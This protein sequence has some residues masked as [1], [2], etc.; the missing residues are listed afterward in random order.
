MQYGLIFCLYVS[1][2]WI[3]LLRCQAL[4]TVISKL[5]LKYETWF[6]SHSMTAQAVSGGFFGIGNRG[7]HAVVEASALGSHQ[8]ARNRHQ[9][10]GS[11]C[12]VGH[13]CPLLCDVKCPWPSLGLQEIPAAFGHC[14]QELWGLIPFLFYLRWL[15]FVVNSL[16]W[17]RGWLFWSALTSNTGP[18]FPASHGRVLSWLDWWTRGETL[19]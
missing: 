10:W 5:P 4:H 6:P 2:R 13:S 11:S 12:A 14:L 19:I 15:R 8:S 18:A 16:F 9:A 3:D 17:G 1:T 7:D